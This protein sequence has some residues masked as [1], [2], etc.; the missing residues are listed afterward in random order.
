[1]TDACIFCR[2]SLVGRES[3]EHILP[4]S[5]GGWLTSRDVCREC[6]SRLGREV[7][8]LASLPLFIALRDEAGLPIPFGLTLEY[9]DSDVGELVKIVVQGEDDLRI[10]RPVYEV[11]GR[12]I[13]LAETAERAAEIA[14]TIADRAAKRGKSVRFSPAARLTSG[15]TIATLVRQA[16]QEQIADLMLRETAKMALEYVSYLAGRDVAL[17]PALDIIRD[18][19]L[20]GRDL[21][22]FLQQA[23]V[24]YMGQSAVW[25]PRTRV[26]VGVGTDLGSIPTRQQQAALLTDDHGRLG[27]PA[28]N[29]VRLQ[30]LNHRLRVR[31]AGT[32]AEFDLVLFGWLTSAVRL[33]SDLPL[34][35][36]TSHYR[37][38]SRGN[39]GSRRET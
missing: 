16:S 12:T 4:E 13:I 6:N 30:D 21:A 39:S 27:E 10:V 28:S 37:N 38:L 35:W 18:A 15:P 33:P 1:M 5:L 3:L 24:H 31:R 32:V 17:D 22:G 2:R 25:L 26:M 19:A 36:G 11:D 7:D 23:R 34:P 14:A 9:D 8:R 20:E 29:V